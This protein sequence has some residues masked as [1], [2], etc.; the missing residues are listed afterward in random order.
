MSDSEASGAT[1]ARNPPEVDDTKLPA[2]KLLE[3]SDLPGPKDSIPWHK[4]ELP[5]DALLLTVKDCE[6][7]SCV[8]SLNPGFYKSSHKDLGY[9]YFGKINCAEGNTPLKIAIT[10]CEMVPNGSTLAVKNTV[11]IL[12]PKAVFCVG[13][14]GGLSNKVK[15]GDVVISSKLRTY[16]AI[17]VTA[18]GIEN[19]GVGVPLNRH[20]AK[21]ILN[22]DAGWKP[23][24]KDE[25][26][27]KVIKNGV[28]LS[29]P[30]VVDKKERRAELIERFPDATAIEMEGEGLYAAARDQEMEWVVIKGVS[31]FADGT[32]SATDAW[33]PFASVMAASLTAHILSDPTAFER[34]AH[35]EG[36]VTKDAETQTEL[37][38]NDMILF[39]Q[40]VITS[41]ERENPD[42]AVSTGPESKRR[43]TNIVQLKD[44]A[45]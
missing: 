16:S 17:R 33:K 38:M 37:T 45:N 28:F 11:T 27:V 25:L 14:C 24:L 44:L 15:L 39:E 40:S 19:R 43:K 18:S 42:G 30:E 41:S 4:V 12:K 7:L 2:G 35:Y 9:V 31:D 36:A 1:I 23:P 8:S 22:A 5:V 20:L 21:L 10:M 29:G 13:F 3:T 26:K 6:F 34:L 32:K